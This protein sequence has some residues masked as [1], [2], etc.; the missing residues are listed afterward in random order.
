[1]FFNCS[2]IVYCNIGFITNTNAGNTPAKSASVP[3][4]LNNLLIVASVEGLLAGLLKEPGRSNSEDSDFRAVIRVF[5]T[6]IG[7]VMRTVALPARAPASMD[8]MVVSLDDARADFIAALSKNARVHSY[9]NRSK[10]DS[11]NHLDDRSCNHTIIIN[12]VR[13]TNAKKCRVQS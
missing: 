10:S 6:Q 1:M 8:S 9:P 4:S 2:N 5:T 12:E 13:H 7:F 3:S 11:V